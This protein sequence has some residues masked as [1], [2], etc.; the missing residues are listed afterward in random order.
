MENRS[1]SRPQLF[2]DNRNMQQVAAVTH[3]LKII[4]IST[5]NNNIT[6]KEGQILGISLCTNAKS[7]ALLWLS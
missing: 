1:K 5:S 4:S 7:F 2:S 3:I 6:L